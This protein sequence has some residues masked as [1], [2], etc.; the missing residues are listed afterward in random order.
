MSINNTIEKITID[1]VKSQIAH[2]KYALVYEISNVVFNKI[3][4]IAEINWDEFIEGYFFNE[5]TQI[6]VYDTEEGLQAVCFTEPADADYIDKEYDLSGRY[7]N[8]GKRIK[9]R[10]YFDYDED[11]QVYVAYTRLIDVI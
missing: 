8:I 5:N 4:K 3:E 1:E 7:Q 10:E 6:H 9:K 2:M 11:G